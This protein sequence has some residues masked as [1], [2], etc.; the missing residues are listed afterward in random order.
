MSIS[1]ILFCSTELLG[2]TNINRSILFYSLS[3]ALLSLFPNT[4]DDT[5]LYALLTACCRVSL[6]IID[7]VA[8]DDTSLVIIIL[9]II[10]SFALLPSSPLHEEL[11]VW[12]S[13]F[14]KG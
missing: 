11:Y 1:R 9:I 10:I 6:Q 3:L 5:L 4:F 13:K 8:V 12:I 7:I 14:E 2:N